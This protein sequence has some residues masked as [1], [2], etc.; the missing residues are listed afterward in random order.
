MHIENDGTKTD[1]QN[2]YQFHELD[3]VGVR[4]PAACALLRKLKGKALL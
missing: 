3:E 1:T 4:W 2:E